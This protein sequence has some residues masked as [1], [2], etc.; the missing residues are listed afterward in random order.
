MRTKC[1]EIEFGLTHFKFLS[2]ILS[3]L[4]FGMV[5]IHTLETPHPTPKTFWTE[6]C[7]VWGCG[8]SS[9]WLS[10]IPKARRDAR[11]IFLQ[12]WQNI[13]QGWL[14]RWFKIRFWMPQGCKALYYW[15]E[16]RIENRTV[17]LGCHESGKVLMILS[18]PSPDFDESKN[19]G[20]SVEKNT[21]HEVERSAEPSVQFFQRIVPFR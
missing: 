1:H 17:M 19:L 20:W 2:L 9:V 12:Y 18:T 11:F 16:S 13:T 3:Y 6:N 7:W 14:A 10:T 21:F 5:D 15:V 8:V 4:V